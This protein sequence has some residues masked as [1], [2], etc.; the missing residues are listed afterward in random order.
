M[1][2]VENVKCPSF[3]PQC[4]DCVTNYNN[5][6]AFLR[7]SQGKCAYYLS[8]QVLVLPKRCVTATEG[9]F[10]SIRL[11]SRVLNTKRTARPWSSAFF[12]EKLTL[13]YIFFPWSLFFHLSLA[14]NTLVYARARSCDTHNWTS[15]QTVQS[16][17]PVAVTRQCSLFKTHFVSFSFVLRW[18]AWISK[19]N[20]CC[21]ACVE[22]ESSTL[23][24]FHSYRNQQRM[25]FIPFCY[26]PHAGTRVDLQIQNIQFLIISHS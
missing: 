13:T 10:Y 12:L 25:S 18:K 9:R 20:N 1:A 16:N 4:L 19:W 23:F 17:K 2:L 3:H 24:T 6:T 8:L 26:P 7:T 14:K 22:H 5:Y 11:N 15:W 21:E